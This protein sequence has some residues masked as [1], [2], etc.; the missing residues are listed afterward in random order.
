MTKPAEASSLC[1]RGIAYARLGK[2]KMAED[3]FAHAKAADAG[4]VDQFAPMGLNVHTRVDMSPSGLT[5]T[6]GEVQYVGS[7]A[8]GTYRF[9]LSL[10]R[11]GRWQLALTVS[12][13]DPPNRLVEFIPIRV[14]V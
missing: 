13:P 9:R 8:L 12:I 1:G 14:V 7:P 4:I 11:S 5:N 3:D 2:K 6:T 10:S